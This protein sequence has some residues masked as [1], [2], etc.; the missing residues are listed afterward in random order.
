MCLKIKA[1]NELCPC[2]GWDETQYVEDIEHDCDT[3]EEIL[4]A[5]WWQCPKC[6]WVWDFTGP[7]H[8]E[9]VL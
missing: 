1:S 4:K 5:D 9:E 7:P 6:D 2:C 8:P 3:R